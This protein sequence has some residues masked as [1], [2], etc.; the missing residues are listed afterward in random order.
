MSEELAFLGSV[1]HFHCKSA[2]PIIV[3]DKQALHCRINSLSKNFHVLDSS[4][5]INRLHVIHAKRNIAMLSSV[6]KGEPQTWR[7]LPV[8][9]RFLRANHI[10]C[11]AGKVSSFYA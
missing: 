8:S 10:I 7:A 4:I 3:S 1:Y 5:A 6:E 11:L 9:L 2:A